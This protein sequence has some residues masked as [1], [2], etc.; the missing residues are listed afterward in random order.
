MEIINRKGNFVIALKD[1]TVFAAHEI[2][3]STS[4]FKLRLQNLE[5]E[6]AVDKIQAIYETDTLEF[7]LDPAI[8][9]TLAALENAILEYERQGG[10]KASY[11]ICGATSLA[12]TIIPNR[13]TEDIDIITK[14]PIDEFLAQKNLQLPAQIE[15]LPPLIP[16][17][18]N[19]W[20][21]LM[22]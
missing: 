12:L 8:L 17:M 4:T 7:P 22:E 1:Q 5:T 21:I 2:G 13:A 10:F 11:T 6:I 20:E 9:A 15:I 14:A 19:W 18:G 16:R 3:A